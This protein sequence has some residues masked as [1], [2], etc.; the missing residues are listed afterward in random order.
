MVDSP[1]VP[2]LDHV[3]LQVPGSEEGSVTD[4]A[5]KLLLP[6]VIVLLLQGD[7]QLE[8]LLE[9]GPV[10]FLSQGDLEGHLEGAAGILPQGDLHLEGLV[11][12]GG[13]AG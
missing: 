13:A 11:E 12:G 3:L 9:G 4:I 7:L 5:G 10:V 1:P 8:G 2:S 6:P